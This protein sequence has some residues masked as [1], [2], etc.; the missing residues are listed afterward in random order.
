MPGNATAQTNLR[1]SSFF[2]TLEQMRDLRAA[3]IGHAPPN[4]PA[5]DLARKV[6]ELI[7]SFEAFPVPTLIAPS[8]EEGVGISFVSG[9]R[10]ALLECYN[11]GTIAVGT[12]DGEKVDVRP[13]RD[14]RSELVNALEWING[15]LSNPR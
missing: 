13:V 3:N 5:I 12:V 7:Q 2:T 4:A 9:H 1:M 15:F 14:A 10:R 6:L 11:D 8:V